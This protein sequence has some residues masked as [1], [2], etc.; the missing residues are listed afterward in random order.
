MLILTNS[1]SKAHGFYAELAAWGAF[2]SPQMDQFGGSVMGG[3][4]SSEIPPRGL[5]HKCYESC[6]ITDVAGNAEEKDRSKHQIDESSSGS[7]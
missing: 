2:Q 3:S 1:P 4:F 6:M 7:F 5:H